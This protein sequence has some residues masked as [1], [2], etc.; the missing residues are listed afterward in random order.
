MKPVR[1]GLVRWRRISRRKRV[2][3]GTIGALFLFAGMFLCAWVILKPREMRWQEKP[4]SHWIARLSHIDL[5]DGH[6]SAEEFLFAA[7]PGVV[8]ALERGLE[9]KDAF[10]NDLWTDIYFKK[11]GK[12]QRHFSMPIK[13]EHYR[14]NCAKALGLVGGAASNA[15][16]ALLKALN[17]ESIWVRTAA[18]ESLSRIAPGDELVFTKLSEGSASS[19]SQYQLACVMSL[20]RCSPA[21]PRWGEAIRRALQ[22]NDSDVRSW[23][24]EAAWRE[25]FS[26]PQMLEALLAAL[27]DA[28]ATVRSRAAESLG[29]MRFSPDLTVQA[30]TNALAAEGNE[31]V[32]WHIVEAI[33]N[34]GT[35]AAPAVEA[36]KPL[37]AL[38][39]HTAILSLIAL[40]RIEPEADW[41]ERL[42]GS[43]TNS[44]DSHMFS[45]AWELGRRGDSARKAVP[46]LVQLANEAR[47]W[48]IET[49]AR[50]AAWRLDPASPAPFKLISKHLAEEKNGF[51]EI[52]RLLEEIGPAASDAVPALRQLRY[53]R[54]IMAHDYATA[55][56][57]AIAPEYV[58]D[59]WK[60]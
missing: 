13:R 12:R 56:L 16:P 32:T 48:R 60:E 57:N 44:I 19:N 50:A 27:Q 11:L 58:T 22:S 8:P 36:L 53:S 25:R 40:S 15:V 59:P 28:Q 24:A 39:N 42:I 41:I 10:L 45:A 49:M 52:I 1:S 38:T 2:T 17:D 43:L 26:H 46:P 33:G 3:I 37:S 35:N 29:K 6:S 34:L 51:Y 21:S 23:A 31:I 4:A 54:G 5:E 18:A 20:A 7:G 14:A 30:L 9:L 47:D 55:A